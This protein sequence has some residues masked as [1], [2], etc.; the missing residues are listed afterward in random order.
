MHFHFNLYNKKKIWKHIWVYLLQSYTSDYILAVLW[1][2]T[3]ENLIQ[4]V[5]NYALAIVDARL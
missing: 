3:L 2:Q 1:T 5:H 4:D